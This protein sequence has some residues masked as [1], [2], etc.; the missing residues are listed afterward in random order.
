V[1]RGPNSEQRS[2]V[3][4]DGICASCGDDG[5][6][7]EVD[8]VVPFATGGLTEVANLQALC[9][10]CHKEKTARDMHSMMSGQRRVRRRGIDP[11]ERI[12][13]G[14][15]LPDSIWD[16]VMGQSASRSRY[17]VR[18][19]ASG[20]VEFAV[21]ELRRRLEA[22]ESVEGLPDAREATGS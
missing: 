11:D 3:L 10:L 22:G 21:T 6:L 19:S 16:W 12:P 13:R 7:L 8:H 9:V 17:G 20:M 14:V 1:S 5:I 18:I 4:A 2:A 15:S